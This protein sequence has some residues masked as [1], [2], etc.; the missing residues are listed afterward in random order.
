[1]SDEIRVSFE[2]KNPSGIKLL[3]RLYDV[4]LVL[5]DIAVRLD[6]EITDQVELTVPTQEDVDNLRSSFE[7]SVQIFN[8]ITESYGDGNNFVDNFGGNTK[9]FAINLINEMIDYNNGIAEIGDTEGGLAA[10]DDDRLNEWI[11][12]IMGD[13]VETNESFNELISE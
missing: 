1:M 6:Q 10:Y 3:N 8:D 7:T 9:T 5:N 11:N 12:S 4:H 13:I 2:A